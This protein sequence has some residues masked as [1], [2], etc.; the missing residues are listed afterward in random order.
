MNDGNHQEQRD[1]AED[2]ALR[3]G[4]SAAEERRADGVGP[5]QAVV[6]DRSRVGDAEDDGLAVVPC[7]VQSDRPPE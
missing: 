2:A 5:E 3:A 7:C 4:G 6:E 1:E